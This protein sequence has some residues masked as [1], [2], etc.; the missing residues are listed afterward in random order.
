MFNQELLE[1][2][3]KRSSRVLDVGSGSGY[4]TLAFAKMMPEGGVTY[5]IEHISE[6]VRDSINNIKKYIDSVIY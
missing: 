4:L 1:D 3:L 5:G 2:H 6:L